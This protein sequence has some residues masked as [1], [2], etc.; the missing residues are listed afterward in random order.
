[1]R[2]PAVKHV[3]NASTDAK[4]GPSYAE[5]DERITIIG[6]ATN[7]GFAM[8]CKL[9]PARSDAEYSLLL[10]PDCYVEEVA[11]NHP[12]GA[13]EK[14]PDAG[15]CGPL[16]LNPDGS[17]QAGGRR[18]IPTPWRVFVRTFGLT[19]LPPI[20]SLIY[21]PTLPCIEIRCPIALLR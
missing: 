7:L 11:I 16:L 9:G 18:V 5:P 3:D 1:M 15:I 8:A 21:L 6:S 10:N 12:I 20:F 14:I 19:P 13:L 17:E 2:L 4:S